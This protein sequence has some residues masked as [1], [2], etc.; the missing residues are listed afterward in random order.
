MLRKMICDHAL[1]HEA[2]SVRFAHAAMIGDT[3]DHNL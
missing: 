1:A 3:R 2:E